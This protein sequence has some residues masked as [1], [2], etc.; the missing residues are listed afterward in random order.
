MDLDSTMFGIVLQPQKTE[1]TCPQC[2]CS[3]SNACL[4]QHPDKTGEMVGCSWVAGTDLC[5]GCVRPQ[6]RVR[7]PV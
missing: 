5:S 3:A 1:R 7:R 4:V 2:G 6:S